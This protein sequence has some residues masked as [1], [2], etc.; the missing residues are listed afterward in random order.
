MTIIDIE[1]QNSYST[2]FDVVTDTGDGHVK[3]VPLFAS[4]LRFAAMEESR[5]GK[6]I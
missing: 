5:R 1:D 6:Q 4:R 2:V 3:K